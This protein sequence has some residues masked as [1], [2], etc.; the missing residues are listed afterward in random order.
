MIAFPNAKINIGLN[1]LNKR[2]DGYH[3]IESVFY[4][5]M[6]RDALEISY[7]P[8][9]EL[10]TT[11]LYISGTKENNLVYKAYQ[12]LQ[13]YITKS[14]DIHLHLH[15]A[16][17]MGAGLGG[18]SADGAFALVL[19]NDY[20]KLNLSIKTLEN[21]AE[22]LGSD[23]PFFIQNKPVFSYDRGIMFEPISLKLSSY[24]IILI[25]PNIHIGTAEA[26]GFIQP[27][28]PTISVKDSIIKPMEEWRELIVN[29][30]EA[31]LM[32][33][34]PLLSNIKSKLYK[35]GAVYASM[36]GSGSTMYGIFKEEIE[37]NKTFD[38]F[39][40]WQGKLT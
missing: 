11:G 37:L 14:Q 30:F 31:P 6:W 19:I 24:Y 13:S 25:N 22:K 40:V 5:I 33:K 20:F 34:Y 4:P 1:I 26:Y 27:K 35:M 3:N 18:G 8:Q 10:K 17:P 36:T 23:C 16:I 29:D 2:D 32:L 21:L 9:F 7:G 38:K 15:K 28:T 39:T 12:L